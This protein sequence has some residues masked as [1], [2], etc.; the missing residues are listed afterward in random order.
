MEVQNNTE[1][2]NN[3]EYD[4]SYQLTIRDV[5]KNLLLFPNL[6]HNVYIQELLKLEYN[7]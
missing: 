3:E 1:T 5:I 2:E 7:R 6:I 4:D